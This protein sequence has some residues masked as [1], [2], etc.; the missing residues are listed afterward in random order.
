LLRYSL[1]LAFAFVTGA[2]GDEDLRLPASTPA[3][4]AATGGSVSFPVTIQDSGGTEVRLERMPERIISLSPGATEVLFAIGAGDRVVATDRFSDFPEAATR[5]PKIEYSNPSPEAAL[6]LSPDLVIM[7]TRQQQQVAQFRELGMTVF[8]AREAADLGQVY[9]SIELLGR[10]TGHEAEAA[11][12]V[13]SMRRDIDA[14]T[15]AIEGVTQG[16]RVFVEISPTLSTASP[17]T[18]IGGMI[19]L[20]KGR[21]IAPDGTVAFPQLTA[22]AVLAAD[23]EVVILTHPGTPSEVAARPGWNG[24]A[25]VQAGRV[26]S[27]DPNVVTRPGPRLPEGI[28]ALGRALYPE[29]IR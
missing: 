14:V 1:A 28:R 21:N 16:P 22:E 29:L 26:I 13:A 2:C 11:N 4:A 10:L 17:S 23:P 27:V 6:A 9:D 5:L 3:P 20:L 7:A 12:V 19:G 24:V 25:A 18:F 15:R 8:F